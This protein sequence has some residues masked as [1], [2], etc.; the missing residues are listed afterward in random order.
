MCFFERLSDS[1]WKE[2][3]SDSLIGFAAYGNSRLAYSN[4]TN[5]G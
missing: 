1:D 4:N 2:T 3:G 5:R